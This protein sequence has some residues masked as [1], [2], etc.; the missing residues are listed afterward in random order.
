MVFPPRGPYPAGTPGYRRY[1]GYYNR[2]R[3]G[4]G[5]LYTL[6][7][8]HPAALGALLLADLPAP[9]LV[10]VSGHRAPASPD[11]APGRRASGAH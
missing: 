11:P 1:W 8:M 4:C 10:L 7:I 3:G 5:C 9:L 2:P 6:L